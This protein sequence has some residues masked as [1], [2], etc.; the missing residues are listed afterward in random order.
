[1]VER[2]SRDGAIEPEQAA[3]ATTEIK[4]RLLAA[5]R[6][7]AG[8]LNQLTL[9]QKHLSVGLVV[10][11][12][13]LGSTILYANMGRPDLPSVSHSS[14]SLVL[15]ESGDAPAFRSSQGS[16]AVPPR[17]DAP[18]TGS[19]VSR[20]PA[21]GPA[22]P[23]LGSVDDM[24]ERL[25]T[26]LAKDPN[27][28][29]TLRMIGWS[30]FA[31]DRFAEAADAYRKAVDL[32]PGNPS[33]SAALGEALVRAAQ[34]EVTQAAA[35]AFDRALAGD[36][37]EPRARFF[38]GLQLAQKGDKKAALEA[39]LAL[40]ADAKA[41]DSWAADLRARIE[42][43]ARELNVS[44]EERL[45]PLGANSPG[46]PGVLQALKE[47]GAPQTPAPVKGPTAEQVR[48]AEAMSPAD[49]QAMIRN[50]VDQLAARLDK[51]PRDAEGWI[52][53]IRSRRVLGEIEPARAALTKALA[54]FGDTPPE[55][56][57]IKAAAAEL[58]VTN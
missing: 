12:V 52:Q 53:L 9:G 10:A 15:G 21:A 54:E 34:G 57:R 31:T 42:E 46:Q 45:P 3:A 25:K 20:S 5:T 26:R 27:N 17:G 16:V 18:P 22:T 4:R 38:K 56:A 55:Q 29:E 39:W 58:G 2:E 23:Q 24:I 49:R 1:E 6:E 30:Y 47:Q 50:M 28:V 40:A 51:S 48:S 8:K 11:I 36:A 35:A 32:A 7:T 41:E 33:L 19:A 14:T 44:I 13:V 43:L 37:K